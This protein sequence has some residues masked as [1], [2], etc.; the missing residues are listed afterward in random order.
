M[1][2]PETLMAD[3]SLQMKREIRQSDQHYHAIAR[4]Y[5]IKMDL[6][7]YEVHPDCFGHDGTVLEDGEI[8]QCTCDELRA[9]DIA[10]EVEFR[11]ECWEDR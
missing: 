3:E 5:D 4:L 9:S 1:T 2:D 6:P 8:V 7:E 10:A 11:R